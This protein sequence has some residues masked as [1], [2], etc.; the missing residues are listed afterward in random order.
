MSIKSFD[1]VLNSIYETITRYSMLESVNSVIVGFS[2]GADSTALLHFLYFFASERNKKFNVEAVHVNHGLRG[3][4]SERDENFVREFCQKFGIKLTVK[5]IDI[6]KFSADNKIGLEEAGRKSRYDIFNAVAESKS[7]HK[8]GVKIATAHTLSDSCETLIF[9]LARGTS[10]KGLCGIPPVRG[11]IIRPLIGITREDVEAYCK[12]NNLDYVNDSTNFKRDYTRNKIR[13]DIIPRLKEINKNF[14]RTLGRNLITLI[15]E[16][17]YLESVTNKEFDFVKRVNENEYD[18]KKIINLPCAIRNRIIAKIIKIGSGAV[19]EQKYV[20]CTNLLLQGGKE[21]NLPN[22]KK[23]VCENDI[24]KVKN[25]KESANNLKWEYVFS[26]NVFLTE[27]KTNIIIEVRPLSEYLE[28]KKRFN[29]KNILDF[30]KI[31][32][33]AIIRNRR[34]GDRFCFSCRNIT[35]TVKKLMNELKIPPSSRNLV[36]LIAHKNEVIWVD[37]V[38]AAEGYGVNKQTKKVAIIYKE[39]KINDGCC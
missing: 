4:E 26:E 31:P 6:A 20:E 2:G 36:P 16:E 29:D 12:F 11:N 38:G 25:Q 8:S 35:K 27:I 13:L 17:E 21:V 30:E 10:L 24:L 28:N 33:D 19:P 32:R 9:N 37:G 34:T 7:E 18:A 1:E 15:S 23:L 14:E 3:K 22:K 39:Q 5:K